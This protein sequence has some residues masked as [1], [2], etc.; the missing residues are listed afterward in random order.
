MN[1][2]IQFVPGNINGW[3]RL[4]EANCTWFKS[5]LNKLISNSLQMKGNFNSPK[6]IISL[7]GIHENIVGQRYENDNPD[8]KMSGTR[9]SM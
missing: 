5:E 6:Y 9:M 4:T 3:E 2:K 8:T 1:L 7:S